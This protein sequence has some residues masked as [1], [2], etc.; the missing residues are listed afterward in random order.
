VCGMSHARALNRYCASRLCARSN[1][2]GSSE[3]PERQDGVERIRASA[4]DTLLLPVELETFS[5]VG[6]LE[7]SSTV[8]FP[9]VSFGARARVAK[10]LCPR[11]NWVGLIAG[12]G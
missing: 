5:E 2:R 9:N 7:S 3:I 11:T 12:A 1:S 6:S 10:P 8:T 4:S